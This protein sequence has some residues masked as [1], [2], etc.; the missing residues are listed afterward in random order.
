MGLSLDNTVNS[1]HPPSP[2]ASSSPTQQAL[3]THLHTIR[4]TPSNI[5]NRFFDKAFTV[6][7]DPSTR[8]GAM[9]E[10]SP[11]DALVPSIVAEWGVVEGVDAAMFDNPEPRFTHLDG[12]Q[13]IT[14]NE[15]VESKGWERLDWV[16]DDE[17]RRE[18]AEAH[19]RARKIIENS[20]DS[21]LWF[22][23]YGTDWI[24]GVGLSSCLYSF[25]FLYTDDVMRPAKFSPDAYIQMVLQLAW[26]KTRGEFTATYE[27]ALT[28]M[29]KNGRTETIRT[30]TRDSRAFV[31]A[32]VDPKTSVG[33]HIALHIRHA[34]L[35]P[36]RLIVHSTR[37]NSTS[38]N[39]SFET[40][41][42]TRYT[43]L[44]RAIQT[45]TTLTREAAT[46]RGIDRHLLGLRF[47]LR[48]LNGERAELF[49][50]ELFERSSRWKLSTSGL[51]AGHLFRGTG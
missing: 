11:C 21:V 12:V 13:D 6:I 43:H 3:D 26:Y 25:L 1:I 36:R 9:G 29:F 31:L 46:G 45:H 20:D 19:E 50:D 40:Q 48:P 51:S 27:T 16:V 22:T 44:R 37:V 14:G 49:E 39:P 2:S 41:P 42:A 8:A 38:Y 23:D 4:S 32:M 7:V 15:Q 34:I 30:L 17:I 35:P 5:P 28:R 24:K 47:M 33:I 10:H 18:C